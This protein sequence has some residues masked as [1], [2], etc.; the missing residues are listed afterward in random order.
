MRVVWAELRKELGQFVTLVPQGDD[1]DAKETEL[2]YGGRIPS[3]RFPRDPA[4]STAPHRK[5][6]P[7]PRPR[8][9]TPEE[10]EAWLRALS[11]HV[12][13][14][15]D[16]FERIERRN[17][18][19]SGQEAKRAAEAL[20]R[21]HAW[22]ERRERIDNMDAALSEDRA[23]LDAFERWAQDVHAELHGNPAADP[24]VPSIFERV[25]A[26]RDEALYAGRTSGCAF[27][28]AI[29]ALGL[30]LTLAGALGV[31]WWS[32][33]PPCTHPVHLEGT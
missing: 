11:R 16:E 18:V 14:C 2:E 28:L 29:L 17:S 8:P 27:S 19:Q 15:V 4:E 9:R 25:D 10:M 32:M 33:P 12:N 20:M 6:V 31:L 1:E 13:L 22:I 23:R 5:S 7:P 30:V 24:P 26:S 21:E 3:E